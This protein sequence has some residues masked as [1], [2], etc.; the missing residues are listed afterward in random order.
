MARCVQCGQPN[1]SD[2]RFC[3]N[4]GASLG[5]AEPVTASRRLVTA[6]FVDIVGSTALGESSDPELVRSLQSRYFDAVEGPIRAAGGSV[7][8]FIGDAV[9]G[10]FG[11]PATHE[12]DAIRAVR[13]GHIILGAVADLNTQL[14]PEVPALRVRIGINSGEAAIGPRAWGQAFVAG[15]MVNTAARLQQSAEP[16]QI[17]IGALTHSLVSTHFFVEALGPLMLRGKS[18]GEPVY[19]VIGPRPKP[20]SHAPAFVGRE[21]ELANLKKLVES[22]GSGPSC[23]VAVITGVPGIGKSRLV[24]ELIDRS[25][26]TRHVLTARCSAFGDLPGMAPMVETLRGAGSVA[27][28]GQSDLKAA[29][30]LAVT[31][32][33][34][35]PQVAS[36]LAGMVSDDPVP[37]EEQYW[38][39]RRFFEHSAAGH[40][41]TLRIEDLQ[42]ADAILINF[43]SY[44]TG[45]GVDESI[46]VVGTARPE[47][48]A[49]HAELYGQHG[50]FFVELDGLSPL[51][52][53]EL[54]RQVLESGQ[55]D[56]AAADAL[57]AKSAGNPL[58]VQEIVAFW[59]E[60]GALVRQGWSWKSSAG[61]SVPPS[62]TAVLSSRLDRLAPKP[63]RLL[64]VASVIGE[65]FTW[66]QLRQLLSPDARDTSS[67]DLLELMRLGEIVS[68]ENR[69]RD[70]FRFRHALVRDVAY[71]GL[72]KGDRAKLHERM[73]RLLEAE[74]HLTA[75]DAEAAGSHLELAS[76]YVRAVGGPQEQT[77][78][79]AV[80]AARHFMRAGRRASAAGDVERAMRLLDRA[81]DLIPT[82]RVERAEVLWAL[83]GLVGSAG[84]GTRR[85]SILRDLRAMIASS[86]RELL[87]IA[88]QFDISEAIGQLFYTPQAT[89]LNSVRRTVRDATDALRATGDL[90]A[91]AYALQMLAE[92]EWTA[93]NVGSALEAC[94]E[95]FA[96]SKM[97]GGWAQAYPARMIATLLEYGPTPVPDAIRRA[98]QLLADIDAD[99]WAASYI[100][101]EIGLLWAWSDNVAKSEELLE[102][103]RRLASDVADSDMRHELGWTVGQME[104]LLGDS[105]A[106][107]DHLRAA[108]KHWESRG[109]TGNL[110]LLSWDLGRALWSI[111]AVEELEDMAETVRTTAGHFDIQAQAG[112]RGLLSMVAL[113]RGDV[114]GAD[115]L[116]RQACALADATDLLNLRGDLWSDLASIQRMAGHPAASADS[117]ARALAAYDA[118]QNVRALKSIN[119]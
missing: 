107:L 119:G 112:W 2:A 61:L 55:L 114:V 47:F 63:R 17:L 110:A 11:V 30:E 33:P 118:K 94:E 6:I 101:A 42:W 48:H 43:L 78:K 76:T 10:V 67:A 73:A 32:M 92:V 35:A 19:R 84:Q 100:E 81:L 25:P 117:L 109:H 68:E 50:W 77:D 102:R 104:V 37:I 46:V 60:R 3:K 36:T 7:E 93:G 52:A 65:V 74:Q 44:L 29:I 54:V 115:D 41:L 79:L 105:L 99:L 8:K 88:K 83:L 82:P 26:S 24:D 5:G 56:A 20:A 27:A 28:A 98:R 1:D 85:E 58:F 113:A 91:L 86:G 96:A 39:L 53:D 18:K 90:S 70:A 16:G 106:G 95:G 116:S 89:D 97:Q 59:L 72:A 4:C 103:T 23:T 12:D 45:F 49:E 75:A 13:A 14:S 111:R 9:V 57:Q 80:E 87:V 64:G 108:W 34:Q 71:N 38:A 62:V 69:S 22:E 15:D 51:E 40:G 66:E 31:G 21:M